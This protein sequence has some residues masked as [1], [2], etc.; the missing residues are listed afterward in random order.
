MVTAWP[1]EQPLGGVQVAV[2][3]LVSRED[4][5]LLVRR[6]NPPAAGKWSLPG[7]HVLMGERLHD[8]VRRELAEETA[9]VHARVGALLEVVE[10]V[11]PEARAHYLVHVYR[12]GVDPGVEAQAGDDAAAAAWV[13]REGLAALEA[14][15]GLSEFLE[16]H[17]GFG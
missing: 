15:A 9:L 4:T 14:T 11:R 16:R 8:A 10:I 7:G 3:A 6:A 5:V 2:S 17:R 1:C 13:D 12:V